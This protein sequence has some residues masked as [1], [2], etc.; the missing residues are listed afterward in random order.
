MFSDYLMKTR[1]RNHGS[2]C[3]GVEFRM[4]HELSNHA[5]LTS[6]EGKSYMIEDSASPVNNLQDEMLGC[7]VFRDGHSK[8]KARKKSNT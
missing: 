2:G 7:V 8:I 6:L 4:A 5:I 1:T 3:C